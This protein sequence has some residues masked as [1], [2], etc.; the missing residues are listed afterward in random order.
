MSLQLQ[1]AI[2]VHGC[3]LI[4]HSAERTRGIVLRNASPATVLYCVIIIHFIYQ[5]TSRLRHVCIRHKDNIRV[6]IRAMITPL[7]HGC[8]VLTAQ[9]YSNVALR[10]VSAGVWYL[11]VRKFREQVQFISEVSAIDAVIEVDAPNFMCPPW[12]SCNDQSVLPEQ[13]HVKNSL[14]A[15]PYRRRGMELTDQ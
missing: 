11:A 9:K 1:Y 4:F 12:P 13:F 8:V 5:L 14:I 2:L 15:R 6:Y 3:D 7:W 10:G